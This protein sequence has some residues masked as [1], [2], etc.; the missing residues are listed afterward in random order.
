MIYVTEKKAILS[1]EDSLYCKNTDQNGA[2]S[3]VTLEQL[4]N[5][6]CEGEDWKHPPLLPKAWRVYWFSFP[7]MKLPNSTEHK[8]LQNKMLIYT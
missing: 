2:I 7:K 4:E 8:L 6:A 5:D 3:P 1:K